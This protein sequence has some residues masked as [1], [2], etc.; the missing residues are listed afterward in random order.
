MQMLC[1]I[2]STLDCEI[3][4]LTVGWWLLVVLGADSGVV[5]SGGYNGRGFNSLNF[6]G[7]PSG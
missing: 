5:C 7:R 1:C 3:E 2:D 6:V 4:M